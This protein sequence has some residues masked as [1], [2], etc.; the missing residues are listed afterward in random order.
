MQELPICSLFLDV[1][2]ILLRIEIWTKL[3]LS[4]Y[5]NVS[6][7]SNHNSSKFQ[8]NYNKTNY[9][10]YIFFYSV[11]FYY[12]LFLDPHFPNLTQEDVVLIHT[13]T[14]GRHSIGPSWS[15][16]P[17][18]SRASIPACSLIVGFKGMAVEA[19]V[20]GHSILF[21]SFPSFCSLFCFS[22][23]LYFLFFSI[24]LFSICP[25]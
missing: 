3:L 14:S 18:I 24:H 7:I 2:F 19:T 8:R 6:E 20:K 13:Q 23:F 10:N 16:R 4:G 25:K 5:S 11:L 22:I 12:I 17:P 21:L 1:H 9:L 15:Y